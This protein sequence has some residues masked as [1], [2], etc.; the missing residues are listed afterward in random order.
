MIQP[1]IL[2]KL[3]CLSIF[4]TWFSF[5]EA[6]TL[7][8]FGNG[9]VG[10]IEVSTLSLFSEP[11]ATVDKVSETVFRWVQ[12]CGHKTLHLLYWDGRS[13]PLLAFQQFLHCTYG[14]RQLHEDCGSRYHLCIQACTNKHFFQLSWQ[15]IMSYSS[16]TVPNHT[17]TGKR[18]QWS[19]IKSILFD[20]FRG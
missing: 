12:L 3:I 7:S 19:S 14:K 9:L 5:P 18:R 2:W 6:S 15:Q 13:F 16:I 20:R 8:F 11:D 17:I 4:P 1:S 10:C